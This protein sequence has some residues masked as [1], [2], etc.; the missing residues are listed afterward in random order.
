M[1]VMIL[2]RMVSRIFLRIPAQDAGFSKD[3]PANAMQERQ[4]EAQTRGYRPESDGDTAIYT[5]DL[6][7]SFLCNELCMQF[8]KQFWK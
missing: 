8:E 6:L 3:F 1:R 5:N 7:S 2:K 4:E